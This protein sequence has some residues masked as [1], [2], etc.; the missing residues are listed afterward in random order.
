ML[1]YLVILI[2]FSALTGCSLSNI[3]KYHQETLNALEKSEQRVS[4]KFD[5][6]DKSM[7]KQNEQIVL[8]KDEIDELENTVTKLKH[9]V[10]AKSKVSAKVKEQERTKSQTIVPSR[11]HEVLLGELEHVVIDTVNQTF[12][13]RVDTGAATSSLNAINIEE[14]ERNGKHWVRF[15]LDEGKEENKGAK[16]E[17]KEE[18]KGAKE[19][20]QWIEAR[21]VRYV[22]IRQATSEET[23][24]RAVV[25]LWVTL[26]PIHE[27]AEFTLADR[28]MMTNP[29]LLGRE[30]I[31]DIALVDV[32]QKYIH[33]KQK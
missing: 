6:I 31:R 28:S 17:G 24:R 33:T 16:D 22:R 2:T 7:Q 23:E 4:L 21:V 12:D 3:D 29:I 25:E 10:A 27:K 32:S 30:F 1:K 15:Q 9:K 18:N 14:F 19:P 26:G 13:A 20:S 8:L 5:S 11:N